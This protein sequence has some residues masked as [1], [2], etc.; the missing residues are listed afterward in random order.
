MESIIIYQAK[1]FFRGT[2]LTKKEFIKVFRK[3]FGKTILR[4]DEII[5]KVYQPIMAI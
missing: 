1:H 5:S 2:H 3:V 4:K